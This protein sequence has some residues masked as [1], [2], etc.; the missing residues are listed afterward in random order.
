M[1][2]DRQQ[3]PYPFDE[4]DIRRKQVA[5]RVDLEPRHQR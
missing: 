3:M 4:G 2:T 5:R 1:G